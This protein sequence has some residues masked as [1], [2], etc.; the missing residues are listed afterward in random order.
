MKIFIFGGT[1]EGRQ[2]S[3]ALAEKGG[4]VAVSVVS[5]YGA[6]QQGDHPGIT[7]YTGPR[8]KDEM[9]DLAEG[10]DLIIDATHPYAT[11]ASDN[12]R[13]AADDLRVRMI[14]LRREED[15]TFESRYEEELSRTILWA[16]DRKEAAE[17]ARQKTDAGRKN[18]LL[19][20]GVRDLPFYCEELDLK[21]LYARVLPSEESIRVCRDLG[22]EPGN[23][24]AIQGPFTAQ[25]NEA[26]IRQYD[27]AIMITK[28]SGKTGGFREKLQACR[29][30][31]I[32]AV[33]ISRPEDQ[34]MTYEEVEK[35]CLRLIDIEKQQER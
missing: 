26:L 32:P 35:E 25:L 34:G 7:V 23:I 31:G 12:I 24:I 30:C 19:T 21:R 16:G 11:E 22:I 13:I 5:E 15:K 17:L 3:K 10:Y 14:R 6:R 2:L 27:I 4:E 1:T 29:S 8:T 9:A 33:V 28:E 20:T 18:I